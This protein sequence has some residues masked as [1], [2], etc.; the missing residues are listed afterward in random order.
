[1]PRRVTDY[2]GLTHP[3]RL[4]LLRAVQRLPGRRLAELADEAELHANTAREHLTVLE[5]EGLIVSFTLTTG[6]RGR[7]PVIFH[8]VDGDHVS[9]VARRRSET[10]RA[11]GE[12][13]RQLA[14]DLAECGT[15]AAE[16]VHQL[17][18][19]YEHLDDAG[20]D[21]SL[22]HE[23]LTF[24]LAPCVY[25]P[26]LDRDQPL[27]CSV[28]TRLVQ[29]HLAQVPGPLELRRLD[30][31]FAPERCRMELGISG[32]PVPSSGPANAEAADETSPQGSTA[33]R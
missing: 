15:L 11:H 19:L 14:P 21:P 24:E 9:E 27:V 16:A 8:P 1:M 3:S 18:A 26:V 31:F 7:P 12:A 29:S 4:K 10:A 28:H 32:E 33:G 17:D 23:Q 20:L 6:E 30:P 5:D 13:L 2:R 22:D 25:R